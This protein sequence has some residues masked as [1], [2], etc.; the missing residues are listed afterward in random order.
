MEVVKLQHADFKLTVET[1]QLELS[2]AKAQKRIHHIDTASS[3]QFPSNCAL[4]LWH[5]NNELQA[6]QPG[7]LAHPVFFENR[8]YHINIEFNE[9]ITAARVSYRETKIGKRPLF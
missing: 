3:Y 6:Y 7:A 9:S 8:L 2:Y 5:P 4:E 1:R